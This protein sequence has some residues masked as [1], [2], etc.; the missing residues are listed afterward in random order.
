MDPRN[1]PSHQ[2]FARPLS[3]PGVRDARHATIPPPPYILQAPLRTSQPTLNH[4]PFLP[5][6]N[7]Q[8]DVRHEQHKPLSQSP[9]SLGNYAAGLQREASG[10]AIENRDRVQE[11]GAS[12]IFGDGRTDRY[13]SQSGNGKQHTLQHRQSLH[14]FLLFPHSES[15]VSLQSLAPSDRFSTQHTSI[16]CIALLGKI[17]CTVQNVRIRI[18][19]VLKAQT[20]RTKDMFYGRTSRGGDQLHCR[21]CSTLHNLHSLSICVRCYLTAFDWPSIL[22]TKLYVLFH[23]FT[24]I[25]H[26]ISIFP[27]TAV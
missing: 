3:P 16:A 10:V 17:R 24:T 22:A 13:R 19:G 14:I 9:F 2:P 7:E 26:R 25:L 8:E 15:S 5:R 20:L 23:V 1:T 12:W 6:R 4:D 27:P 21:T 18:D 11:N